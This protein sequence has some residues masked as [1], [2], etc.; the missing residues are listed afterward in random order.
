MSERKI[1]DWLPYVL[2]YAL[3]FVISLAGTHIPGAEHPSFPIKT[4]ALTGVL[5]WFWR[6]RAYPEWDLKPSLLGV[7]AGLL[8]FALWLLPE[9]LLSG[10]P[11]IGEVGYDPDSAGDWRTIV[12][13]SQIAGA[14]LVVPIF[15]ELFLRSFLMRYLDMVKEDRDSF[16]EGLML[17][18]VTGQSRRNCQG[19]TRREFLQIGT[20]GLGGISLASLLASKAVGQTPRDAVRD[21]SVVVLC[22]PYQSVQG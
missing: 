19:T 13:V 16:T 11:K 18:I 1:P 2:P 10:L 22:N 6:A 4:L 8:G 14:V 17:E 15:E 7:A 21:K 3:F 5:F 20:L 9:N 12:I